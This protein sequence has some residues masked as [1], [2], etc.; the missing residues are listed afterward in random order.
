MANSA[1]SNTGVIN[2]GVKVTLSVT[3]TAAD[4]TYDG[5][6]TATVTLAYKNIFTDYS[7]ITVAF[8][9]AAF[10]S[11]TAG[12]NIVVTVNGVNIS[13][14]DSGYFALASSTI[15]TTANINALPTPSPTPVDPVSPINDATQTRTHTSWRNSIDNGP[16]NAIDSEDGFEAEESPVEN[17]GGMPGEGAGGQEGG[18]APGGGSSGNVGFIIN[19][20]YG[21]G[22]SFNAGHRADGEYGIQSRTRFGGVFDGEYGVQFATGGSSYGMDLFASADMQFDEMNDVI[23][24]EAINVCEN[25]HPA[26]KSELDLLL[27][28]V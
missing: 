26:F 14:A 9:D 23:N 24:F 16:E 20:E 7:N 6:T 8:T 21:V 28:A 10:A 1:I 19:G 11:A 12:S 2:P 27:E 22:Q 18:E 17:G 25:K 5:T 3:A 15:Y 4:K 13:G